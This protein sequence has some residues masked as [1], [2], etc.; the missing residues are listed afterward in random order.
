[1]DVLSHCRAPNSA[2][3]RLLAK[4]LGKLF[5]AGYCAGRKSV[6]GSTVPGTPE[7]SECLDALAM[8]RRQ[9]MGALRRW[10]KAGGRHAKG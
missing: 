3:V 9:V 1:M 4:D 8:E 7:R 6:L 2:H 5:E 10:R